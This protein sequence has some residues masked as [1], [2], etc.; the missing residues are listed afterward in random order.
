MVK[1]SKYFKGKELSKS[2]KYLCYSHYSM[3]KEKIQMLILL[4][5]IA[6]TIISIILIFT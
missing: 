6:A 4:I 5:G 1:S 2:S 3:R